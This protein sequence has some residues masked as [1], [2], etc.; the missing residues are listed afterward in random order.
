[1]TESFSPIK[2]RKQVIQCPQ[3]RLAWSKHNEQQPDA[4]NNDQYPILPKAIA[5]EEG[6]PHK[7][8]KS[9]WTNKLETRYKSALPSTFTNFPPWM[10]QVAIINA[11]F[12]INIRPL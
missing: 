10:P 8:N 4:I 1:M 5:N 9:R 11:M 3:R 6:Y 12:L 7:G 2:R